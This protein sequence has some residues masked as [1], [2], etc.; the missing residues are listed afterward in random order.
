MNTLSMN[1]RASQPCAVSRNRYKLAIQPRFAN[2]IGIPNS[3]PGVN[4]FDVRA[5]AAAKPILARGVAEAPE[6]D[7]AFRGPTDEL[8]PV[9]APNGEATRH[10]D[11]GSEFDEAVPRRRE[12]SENQWDSGLTLYLRD[13]GRFKRLTPQEEM[14][15]AARIKK[16]DSEARDR[17][18]QA[19][20]RLVVKIACSY[21]GIG[22]PLLDLISEGNIGLM[23]AVERFD[24]SKGAKLSS[25]GALWIKQAITQAL[26]N[27]SK[28]IR[29]PVH[30]VG[31]LSKMHRASWR[32]QEELGREPSDEELAVELRTSASRLTQM[33][34]AATR[35]ASL[36]AQMD[37]HS[38]SYAE[39]IADEKAETPYEKLEVKTVAEMLR[40]MIKTLNRRQRTILHLRFGLN[41]EPPKSLEEIGKELGVTRERVRQLQNAA[42]ARLRRG[43]KKMEETSA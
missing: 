42:L 22:V 39:T 33:R 24:P 12:S 37:E 34:I 29:L 28:T 38:G 20:L 13:I 7:V 26:A 8:L 43:I 9:S 30:V 4:R 10:E 18:I 35:P 16:G 11:A 2:P 23:R 25:Y 3:A 32:L 15:L 17:M 21:E 27:Q 14:E 36:D 40:D 1:R 5:F 31:K 41:G 6:P 19:N